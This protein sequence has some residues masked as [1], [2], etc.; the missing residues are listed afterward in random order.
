MNGMDRLGPS[1]ETAVAVFRDLGLT[2]REIA[3]YFRVHPRV[4]RQVERNLKESVL[5]GLP[6]QETGKV[7]SEKR[8]P[9]KASPDEA[10]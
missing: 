10:S 5:L 1:P 2:E 3:R 7:K 6:A 9:E 4:V 8:R